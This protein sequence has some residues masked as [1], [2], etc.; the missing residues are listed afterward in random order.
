M[1]FKF[2]HAIALSLGVAFPL[3]ALPTM[4]SAQEALSTVINFPVTGNV[5]RLC[6]IGAVTGGDLT[7]A[8]G[9]LI[10]GTTGFLSSTLTAPA[11]V[12]TGSWCNAPSN[13]T[14]GAGA[15]SAVGVTGAAPAGFTNAVNYTATA[16]GWTTT[17]ASFVI[18]AGANAA[19]TQTSATPNASTINVGI[20][21]FAAAG[22]ATLRPVSAT[23]YNGTVTLTLAIVP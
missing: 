20:G 21:S 9:S 16:S 18:G 15:L 17:P 12:V 23:N 14:I 13:I 3:L 1:T 11:K 4:V 10:D 2:K 5:A 22:G 8:L 6:S 19:A 7:F